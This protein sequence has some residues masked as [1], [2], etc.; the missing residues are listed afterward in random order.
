LTSPNLVPST[1]TADAK[2]QYSIDPPPALA[3]V[4]NTIVSLPFCGCPSWV[5]LSTQRQTATAN[6]LPRAARAWL[7]F[8][9]G[10]ELLLVLYVRM[11]C[12]SAEC[13][14]AI[15]SA[16]DGHTRDVMKDIALGA[17]LWRVDRLMNAHVLGGGTNAG[18]A[19][20]LPRG[21]LESL[22][23][24]TGCALRRIFV[25]NS[26]FAGLPSRST[27]NFRAEY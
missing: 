16:A 12:T 21:I 14:C 13:R 27:A 7:H 6:T 11:G 4:W 1:T 20:L 5:V 23:W 22:V 2:P 24:N 9:G 17:G 3:P 25:R 19:E 8:R 10:M 26:Q 15:S 18:A